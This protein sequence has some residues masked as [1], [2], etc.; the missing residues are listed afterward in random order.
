MQSLK[1]V[2]VSF[3]LVASTASYAN[4]P[5]PLK[6]GTLEAFKYLHRALKTDP[7]RVEAESPIGQERTFKQAGQISRYRP[8]NADHSGLAAVAAA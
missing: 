3:V 7:Y 1:S 6:V 8:V 2:L 4:T 5:E